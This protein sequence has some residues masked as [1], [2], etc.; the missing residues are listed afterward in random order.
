[1][2]ILFIA[3]IPPPTTG[4]AIIS[5]Q[6]YRELKKYHKIKLINLSK[7]TFKQGIDSFGR[8]IS[9]LSIL[10][11]VLSKRRWCDIV[12]LT[13]SQSISG[14]IKD[15]IILFLLRRNKI[16]VH[17]HGGGIREMVY[18]K[19]SF[20][21]MLNR[22]LLRKN[23]TAI[24]LGESL[25]LNF[26]GIVPIKKIK[27]LN[28]FAEEYFFISSDELNEKYQ[29]TEIIKVLF[30]SNMLPGKGYIEVTRA[31]LALENKFPMKFKFNFIG[32]FENN[33]D[34]KKF[35]K[36]I[37]GSKNINFMGI[38]TGLERVKYMKEAHIFTLPS[39]YRFSEG[40]PV[41]ILEAYAAGC[42]VLSTDHGGIKDIFKNKENGFLVEKA[43]S[44]SIE[45]ELIKILHLNNGNM[46]QIGK[47]NINVAQERYCRKRFMSGILELFQSV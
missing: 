31:A 30:L 17:L 3:P 10:F 28:N 36:L 16:I 7:P 47:H 15:I 35:E 9:I 14:N 6:I 27:V 19:N 42:I 23:S 1:M 25:K 22:M 24:V 37:G 20:I 46:M 12:Y 45:K 11:S 21:F 38:L 32:G 44:E 29:S 40:Q 26:K 33:E 2:N 5:D 4:M 43:S 18:E 41:S 34:K 13:L 8:I 39:Y